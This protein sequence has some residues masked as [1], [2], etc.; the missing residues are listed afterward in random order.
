MP[1]SLDV[2]ERTRQTHDLRQLG[3]DFETPLFFLQGALDIYTPA[4]PVQDY[5]AAL[6]APQK[7]LILWDDQAHLTFL[8]NP[9]KVRK[10]L[11]TRVRPAALAG[12][13]I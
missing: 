13:P 6:R 2:L 5:V 10:E 4:A 1:V 7:E 8:T 11:V 12:A 9:E 3:T